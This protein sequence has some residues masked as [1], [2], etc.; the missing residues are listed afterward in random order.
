LKKKKN[1]L[2]EIGSWA[3][4]QPAHYF[5]SF[6]FSRAPAHL[7]SVAQDG[8]VTSRESWNPN[9]SSSHN[10]IFSFPFSIDL[11]PVEFVLISGQEQVHLRVL[12]E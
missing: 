10:R 12:Y 4:T 11:F 9:P 6:S 5:F 2:F 7:G 3:E 8:V 1:F